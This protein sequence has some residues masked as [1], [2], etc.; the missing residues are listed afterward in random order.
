MSKARLR[1]RSLRTVRIF[2][3][4]GTERRVCL[5]VDLGTVVVRSHKRADIELFAPTAGA[6]KVLSHLRGNRIFGD[7]S[8]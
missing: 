5:A 2:T 1:S 8:C 7:I 3:T 6:R 4:C